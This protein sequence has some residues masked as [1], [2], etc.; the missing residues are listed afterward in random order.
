[1][2]LL[3]RKSIPERIQKADELAAKGDLIKAKAHLTEIA[4]NEFLTKKELRETR[5]KIKVIDS[6]ING[7]KRE[8][9][10]LYNISVQY[11]K[12][13]ELEKAREGFVKV[14]GNGLLTM[15]AGKTAEDYLIKIDNTLLDKAKPPEPA[16]AKKSEDS[17]AEPGEV[18]IETYAEKEVIAD[19]NDVS[20]TA[21]ATAAKADAGRNETNGRRETNDS[22]KNLL[23]S[24]TKAV[25]SDA[26]SKAQ[27]YLYQGAFNKAKEVVEEA[28]KTLNKNQSGLG[29]EMFRQ[30]SAQLQQ[31][32]ERIGK[33]RARWLGPWDTKT[34]WRW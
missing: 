22:R 26:I 15:P 1:M 5:E 4:N 17:P 8:V 24:Y 27:N 28:Q 6:Q 25:V 3:E 20:V 33:E 34:A 23:Q 16:E 21:V 9:N 7:Q 31:L 11:Y 32:D 30:Y 13:G 29:E 18:K 12:A 10:E 14:A 2:A 19:P